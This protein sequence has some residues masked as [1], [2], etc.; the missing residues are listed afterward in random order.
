MQMYMDPDPYTFHQMH[1][2]IQKIWIY[3]TVQNNDNNENFDAY[4][5]NDAYPV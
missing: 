3:G 2:F 4:K 5:Y 1:T